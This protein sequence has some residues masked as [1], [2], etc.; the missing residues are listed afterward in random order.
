M[1]EVDD[2]DE[3]IAFGPIPVDDKDGE[4]I[5]SPISGLGRSSDAQVALQPCP[6][7]RTAKNTSAIID[8]LRT[9]G[10]SVNSCATCIG[11]F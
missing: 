3:F 11:H 1:K 5:T 10:K 7:L 6:I 4:A 2:S 8:S 9:P